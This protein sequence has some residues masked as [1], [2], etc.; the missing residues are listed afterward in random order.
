MSMKTKKSSASSQVYCES[1]IIQVKCGNKAIRLVL[2]LD[3]DGMLDFTISW[4]SWLSWNNSHKDGAKTV[5]ALTGKDWHYR[6]RLLFSSNYNFMAGKC[7]SQIQIYHVFLC[8]LMMI[9]FSNMAIFII[10]IKIVVVKH[11]EKRMCLER[12]YLWWMPMI[13]MW[14]SYIEDEE[15]KSIK[16]KLHVTFWYYHTFVI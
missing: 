5:V 11:T 14:G 15:V 13:F 9:L 10:Y 16:Q 12:L 6:W 2:A 8:H 1:N 7:A 3:A 4:A